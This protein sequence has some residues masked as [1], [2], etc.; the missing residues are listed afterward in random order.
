[1]KLLIMQF[2]HPPLASYLLG[3]NIH[4]HLFWKFPV[5]SSPKTFSTITINSVLSN[6]RSQCS[7]L[8][9]DNRE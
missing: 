7:E 6:R 2:P 4:H 8:L 1:M 3:P 5:L 9:P